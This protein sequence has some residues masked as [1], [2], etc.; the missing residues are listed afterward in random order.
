M[1]DFVRRLER[2]FRI[3]YG[4]DPL[5]NET[6]DTLLYCQL[7]EGLCYELM[8][9][10]AV[11]GATKHQELCVAAKNEEK[12]LADLQR[13][14]QYNKSS[15]QSRQTQSEK[16]MANP[17]PL[18]RLFSG[19]R[20]SGGAEAK[21]CFLCKKP[22]HL[23]RDCKMKKSDSAAPGRP[24][25]TRQVTISGP[26]EKETEQPSPYDLLYSSD[27]E[28]GEDVRLIRVTDEGSQSQLA[29]VIVQRVPADGVID[30]GVDITIMGWDLFVKVA[31]AARLCKKNFRK[32]DKVPQTY[33]Q[34]T[35]H[36][37]GCVEVDLH[38]YHSLT[39]P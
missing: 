19:N 26:S 7:Q 27:S 4:R 6:S 25:A 36:L 10:P 33:D 1:A 32:P 30:T 15:A 17:D 22:G 38:M 13:R 34:K 18:K 37:D 9:G 39:R 12:H 3:A 23:M 11:P 5:S 24:V 29:H 21:K 20:S 35:F 2:M 31:A 16:V 14:Q 28:D 8:R